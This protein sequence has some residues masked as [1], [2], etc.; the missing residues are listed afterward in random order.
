MKL[1]V[2]RDSDIPFYMQIAGQ[3]KRQIISGEI[4]PGFRLP[5]ERKLA[6]SLG[7]NRTTVLNA[8]RELK[9]E[10][11]VGSRVGQGTVVLSLLRDEAAGIQNR[12][13]E[14]PWNQIFSKYAHGIDSFIVKDLLTLAN[15]KDVISFA[16]GIAAPDSGPIQALAGIEHD[17]VEQKNYRGLLHSPT[18][19]FS[20]LREAICGLMQPRGV[21]CHHDEVMLLAGSQQGIDLTSRIMLDPGDIVLVEEPSFFPAIQAFRA[22]GTRVVGVPMDERGMR[23]DMLEPI[24][25]RYQP[26]LI[27]TI[28]NFHNPTG[29]EMSL[30]R[31]KQL[32]EL[33]YKHR[34][35]ILEDDAYAD[36]CYDGQPLPTLKSMD[37]EG[38][39]IYLSTFSKTIYSGLRLGWMVA[40]KKAIKKFAAAKQIM[41]L[42]SSSLS[43]WIV[44]RFIV[45]GGLKRHIPVICQEYRVK[46]DAMYDALVQY[47][48]PD[49]RW[50][51]PRGGYYIWCRLPE[52]VNASRL[53][54]KAAERKVVFVP[55]SAFYAAEQGDE[56][57]RL[58]F[59]FAPLKDIGEG[60]KR[61]CEAMKELKESNDES[62]GDEPVE[63]SPIV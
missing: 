3:I 31:R 42:H 26:K 54:G 28:P 15:R 34:V 13:P 33:A 23:V 45:E 27:Y 17:I 4:I 35:L 46:R 50:N 44:E 55:G 57:V 7:I 62:S 37:S 20:T 32:L 60:I 8:Y 1:T 24:L 2:N 9:A 14:P 53:V 18:E 25:H 63:I 36:L 51:R 38:Y 59:T 61:L 29:S 56:Y 10:G 52:K 48:P 49:A 12:V 19:G 40:H 58:N 21:Y 22:A 41:D 30:E 6:E 16:T 39:V 5:P 47:A 43:Q 11:L